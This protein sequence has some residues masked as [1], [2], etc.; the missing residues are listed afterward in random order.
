VTLTFLWWRRT[1]WCTTGCG[2]G[3]QVVV[4]ELEL[5]DGDGDALADGDGLAL[6]VGFGHGTQTGKWCFGRLVGLAEGDGL[7]LV[8]AGL[9]LMDGDGLADFDGCGA[10]TQK[11]GR[12][13]RRRR[14][15]FAF[16]A[17]EPPEDE[18]DAVVAWC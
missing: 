8:G 5:G 9:G 1:A 14:W 11:T 7:A 18:A 4:F 3:W 6:V 10:A 2:N 13:C 15:C 16:V 12:A 17:A